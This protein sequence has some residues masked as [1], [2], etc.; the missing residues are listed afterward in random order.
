MAP[1]LSRELIR[2]LPKGSRVI[3]PMCG[4][5]TVVRQAVE[6]G[7]DCVGRDLDP[8]AVLMTRAWTTAVPAFRLIH[9][10]H[11]IVE[12]AASLERS[13]VPLP[14]LDVETDK[15]ARYWF[16]PA[17]IET[18]SRLSAVL[19]TCRYRSRDLLKVC[20]SRVIVT[21]DR[22]ASLARD[23]SHS[24]PHRV[25]LQNDFDV[26]EGFMRAA[27]LVA[28]RSEERRVGKGV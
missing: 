16:A 11:E 25:A 8:L 12:R 6:A 20:M 13:A 1:E 22:G 5:G 9:D 19:K 2:G 26:Y 17:Q 3:D 27:R 21:K 23:V 28:K 14:W 15:F 18:L 7:H 24:R 10:A 4:S